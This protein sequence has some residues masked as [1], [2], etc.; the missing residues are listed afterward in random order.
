MAAI[1]SQSQLVK[2][3]VIHRGSNSGVLFSLQQRCNQ[4]YRKDPWHA[5]FNVSQWPGPWQYRIA[6]HRMWWTTV[7]QII[8]YD[9]WGIQVPQIYKYKH[10]TANTVSK[11]IVWFMWCTVVCGQS[12]RNRDSDKHQDYYKYAYFREVFMTTVWLFDR[13]YFFCPMSGRVSSAVFMCQ[14]T[15]YSFSVSMQNDIVMMT[16]LNGYIFRVTGPLRGKFT[17][18]RWIP[19]TNAS[20]AEI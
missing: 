11:G 19:L 20:D 1:L 4:L 6:D 12:L 5:E 10:R 13:R 8:C 9:L 7:P 18:H 14:L 3:V 2:D 15:V 17:G 16:S